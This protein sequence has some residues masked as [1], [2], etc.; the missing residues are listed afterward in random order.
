MKEKIIEPV[1]HSKM[2]APIVPVLKPDNSLRLCGDY[3]VTVNLMVKLDSY[4]IPNMRD[5]MA[6]LSNMKVF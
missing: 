1:N 5:L 6:G 4:P 3:K 2:A